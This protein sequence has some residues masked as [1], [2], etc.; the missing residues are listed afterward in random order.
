MAASVWSSPLAVYVITTV[1]VALALVEV[2]LPTFG[3]AGASAGAMG[4]LALWGVDARSHPWWPFV[5]IGFAFA[6]WAVEL[7]RGSRTLRWPAAAA[8]GIGSVSFGLATDDLGTSICAAAATVTFA[9]AFPTL[10][11]AMARLNAARS[12][13]GLDAL[14]G[15]RAVVDRW[16]QGSGTVVVDGS[17]WSAVGPPFLDPGATVTIVGHDRMTLT[18]TSAPAAPTTQ[19]FP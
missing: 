17:R 5:L 11:R 9:A 15:R 10:S 13:I 12:P 18:V 1:A 16:D 2:A 14:D 4:L 7:V 8:F 3:V 19:E 6:L